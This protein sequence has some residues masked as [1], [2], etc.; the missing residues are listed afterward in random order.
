MPTV[1]DACDKAYDYAIVTTKNIPEL[2]RSRDLLAPLLA[3]SYS[4][5]FPQ[6]TYVNMQNGLNV[7]EDLY[8]ALQDLGHQPRVL[9]TTVYIG[10]KMG[11]P[12]LLIHSHFVRSR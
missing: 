7:E 6:P 1:A 4:S 10:T 8:E 3:E 11:G 9:G 12:N 2:T 5:K